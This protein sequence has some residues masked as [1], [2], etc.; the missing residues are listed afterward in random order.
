MTQTIVRMVYFPLY[1]EINT[2]LVKLYYNRDCHYHYMFKS[3]I[4]KNIPFILL[5]PLMIKHLLKMFKS[6]SILFSVFICI[7][8]TLKVVENAKETRKNTSML[9]TILPNFRE[10]QCSKFHKYKSASEVLEW[11]SYCD[12]NPQWRQQV[13]QHFRIKVYLEDSVSFNVCMVQ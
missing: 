12:Q 10:T 11:G 3:I 5:T 6:I 1:L 2:N 13:K 9:I 7:G 8:K 4:Q